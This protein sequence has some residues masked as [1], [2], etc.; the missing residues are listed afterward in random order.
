MK[1]PPGGN[2]LDTHIIINR[3]ADQKTKLTKI[4]RPPLL[5]TKEKDQCGI[6]GCSG[7]RFTREREREVRGQ[8]GVRRVLLASDEATPYSGLEAR[9][10]PL[11]AGLA[12]ARAGASY[13]LPARC[14][15]AKKASHV[16]ELWLSWCQPAARP[17]A[18]IHSHSHYLE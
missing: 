14:G 4:R 17:L 16:E 8:I 15:P 5:A 1:L 10:L 11:L 12:A 3:A 9:H 13:L 18:S 7:S 6:V 2:E